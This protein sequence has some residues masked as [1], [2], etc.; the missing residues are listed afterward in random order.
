[1]W[2][3]SWQRLDIKRDCLIQL[4]CLTPTLRRAQ[5]VTLLRRLNVGVRHRRGPSVSIGP[6]TEAT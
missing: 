6:E 3:L 5:F 4:Q 2:C 1:M